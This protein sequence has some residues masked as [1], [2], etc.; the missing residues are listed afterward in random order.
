MAKRLQK[1][2]T[3]CQ[4]MLTWTGGALTLEKFVFSILEWKFQPD[5]QPYLYDRV[6][7]VAIPRTAPER[8]RIEKWITEIQD[9]G[10]NP[11]NIYHIKQLT[12][13]KFPLNADKSTQQKY[14]DKCGE[15]VEIP[16][17]SST[18]TQT[19]LGLQ[20]TPKGETPEAALLFHHRNQRF[21][22]RMV[23]SRLQPKEV[24]LAYRG[25]QIPSQQYRFHGAQFGATFLHKESNF[26]TTKILPKLGFARTHPLKLRY[27]PK[28]R[29]GLDLPHYYVIQ[30]TTS[31][32]QAIQHIRLRTELGIT[33]LYHLKWTQLIIG[34]Q[35]GILTE[36]RTN[37]E[38]ATNTWWIH[39]RAFLLHIQGNLL[40]EENYTIRPLREN[41]YSLMERL[42]CSGHYGKTTLRRINACRLYLR[43][44][45]MSEILVNHHT[46][47]RTWLTTRDPQSDS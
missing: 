11:L 44:T 34:F 9:Q 29:G 13:T 14:L 3:N 28:N 12:G 38:Y 18:D 16:Q 24:Q 47:D 33:M 41:N 17:K 20:M 32:K 21:G 23:S 30:G 45:Y 25:V 46:L 15:R 5:G 39:V 27:A 42:A 1:D 10:P 35:V 31:I 40:I 7:W 36:V 8:K 43:I 2:L 19:Y 37:V 6:H 26:L 4:E 22:I